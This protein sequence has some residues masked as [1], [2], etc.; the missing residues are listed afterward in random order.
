MMRMLSCINHLRSSQVC[1]SS[2][3]WYRSLS[4]AFPDAH[5]TL[6]NVVAESDFVAN[7]FRL[8]G[9]QRGPFLGVPP[10]GKGIDVEGV[11]ILKFAQGKCV[12]RWS[13]T[14]VMGIMRQISS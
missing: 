3:A 2:K 7:N 6:G 12:E 5:I 10:S 13:Q 9:T 14:D 8:R 1:K 4:A 11:T